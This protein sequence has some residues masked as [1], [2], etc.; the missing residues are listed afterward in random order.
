MHTSVVTN[1]P[2]I[3]LKTSST[4]GGS[5]LVLETSPTEVMDLGGESTTA[6]H[7]TTPTPFVPDYILNICLC[8][9]R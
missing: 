4:K 6:N 9:H 7:F 2:L 1:S 5:R 3:G 8:I